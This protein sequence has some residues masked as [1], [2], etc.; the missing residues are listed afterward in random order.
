MNIITI[1]NIMTFRLNN[2]LFN[3]FQF[4]Y[5]P[6]KYISNNLVLE[7]SSYINSNFNYRGIYN[8]KYD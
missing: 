2:S 1:L 3:Y 5:F 7:Y 4:L 8:A 6:N